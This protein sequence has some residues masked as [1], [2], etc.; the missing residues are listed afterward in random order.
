MQEKKKIVK[1]TSKV[2]M[3]PKVLKIKVRRR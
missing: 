1:G 2:V 3:G